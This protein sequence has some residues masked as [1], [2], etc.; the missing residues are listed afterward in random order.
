MK[1][2]AKSLVAIGSLLAVTYCIANCAW[3]AFQERCATSPAEPT[4]CIAVYCAPLGQDITTESLP[5]IFTCCFGAPACVRL[6]GCELGPSFLVEC[7][8]MIYEYD[9]FT[10]TCIGDG[11]YAGDADGAECNSVAIV[12]C[13]GG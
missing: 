9:V 1:T 2:Y 13:H 12:I 10:N 11:V 6:E 3:D 7:V 4:L 5:G 8:S